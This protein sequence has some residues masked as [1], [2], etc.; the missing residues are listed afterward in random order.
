MARN[1]YTF[2][3]EV[4]K[5]QGYEQ[6]ANIFIETAENEKVHADYFWSL[7]KGLG[8]VKIEM[9]VPEYGVNDT[10]TNLRNAA[11]GEYAEHTS[12][13]PHFADVAEKEGF[14]KIAN[15]FCGIATVE[16]EHEMRFNTLAKQVETS[17]VFKRETV[18]AWKCRYCGAVVR[19]KET[20]ERC[21]VCFKPQGFFEIKET[22]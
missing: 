7:I 2:F 22:I 20:P 14:P 4:A 19:A 6:I 1:R 11:A 9:E 13:Y 3:A 16:K 8:S 17:S 5:K 21:P 12:E 15:S 18:V 10:L